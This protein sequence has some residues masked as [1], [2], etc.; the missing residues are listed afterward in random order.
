MTP[1]DF[2]N[3]IQRT[4]THPSS[5]VPRRDGDRNLLPFL[6]RHALS[7]T[8]A[9]VA[10]R[11]VHFSSSR[12]DPG[13]GFSHFREFAQ[14]RCRL[15]RATI[16]LTYAARCVVTIDVHGPLDRV[17]DVSPYRDRRDGLSRGCLRFNRTQT[18]FP[19]SASK[20]HPLC[21]RRVHSSGKRPS[22][23]ETDQPRS[24]F[25]TPPA[26]AALFQMIRM[27]STAT[28]DGAREDRSS[29]VPISASLPRRPHFDPRLG[30]VL[31]EGHC[32]RT[33]RVSPRRAFE[34]ADAFFAVLV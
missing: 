16:V 14:P 11:A 6:T 2:C 18:T 29:P 7:R 28:K 19:S 4:G 23:T 34:S 32:R 20:E 15:D 30:K 3:C 33:A 22:R 10:R 31:F 13:V 12:D 21:R 27:L 8:G 25:Q 26:K 1:A 24:S 9:V 5:Y 17:K